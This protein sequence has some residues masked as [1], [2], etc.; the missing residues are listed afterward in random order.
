MFG[1]SAK[2]LSN[3]TAQC[4]GLKKYDRIKKGLG[5]GAL[6]GLAFSL[7]FLLVCAFFPEA[8]CSLFFK[9]EAKRRHE[10]LCDTLRAGVCAADVFVRHE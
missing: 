2:A 4:M 9:P 10:E 1:N 7:P 8:V 5:A 3:H 6:Q